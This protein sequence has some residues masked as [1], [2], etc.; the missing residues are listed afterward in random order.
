MSEADRR[1]EILLPGIVFLAGATV[2]I[3]EILGA[4][5]LAPFFGSTQYVWS[6]LIAVTL[7]ALAL[8]YS[9]GGRVADLVE[10]FPMLNRGLVAAGWLVLFVPFARSY[11]LPFAANFGIRLGSL[12]AALV[13]L[14]PALT[15]LGAVAPLAAKTAVR[16]LDTLGLRVGTLYA[17]STLGSLCGALATG[18]LLIP[19]LG[20][21]R[22]LC[23]S[24]LLLFGPALPF[25]LA[26]ARGRE[27]ALW[28]GL[29]LAGIAASLVGILIRP[30]YPL[31]RAGDPWKILHK[32]ESAYGEIK[33]V[34]R[35]P[36]RIMLLSGSLQSAIEMQ[37]R[38]S[39]F[40]YAPA[41]AALLKTAH[42]RAKRI[43][44]VGLGGGV[45]AEQLAEEGMSV[46]S[47]EIDPE[48]ISAARRFFL[49][50][51]N[52]SV[53]RED[54]R[55]FLS[56]AAPGSYDAVI[57][58]AYTAEAPPTHLLTVEAYRLVRRAL[59]ADGIGIANVISKTEGEESSF[60]R[61]MG[62]TLREVFPWVEA[63]AIAKN[64]MPTNILYVFGSESRRL[65]K[66]APVSGYPPVL[67]RIAGLLGNQIDLSDQK[68]EAFPFTDDY[69]PAET[70]L[71][72]SLE[73]MRAHLRSLLPPW[74][75]LG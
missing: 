49:K 60:T 48:V 73:Y 24:A 11:V 27:R 1:P 3:L 59:V 7:L 63:Y 61:C 46:D 16:G 45:L 14:A 8:G 4:K 58:D 51:L 44:I 47:I 19:V 28:S 23:L 17:L 29:A 20:V 6:S 62:R 12:L 72:E 40:E 35:G 65:S 54:A 22:I 37:N 43:L 26:F 21:S 9:F 66:L 52:L 30:H 53:F 13:L 5:L 74:I 36:A 34:Q 25:W 69:N 67:E 68:N 39:L 71:T 75:L 64:D 38:E 33:V 50:D 70:M 42:P 41:M 31:E 18:F 15:I 55:T 56:R 57:M 10:P 2:L 32:A